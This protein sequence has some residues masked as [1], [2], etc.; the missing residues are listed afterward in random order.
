MRAPRST[1]SQ[2]KD[3]L[4]DPAFWFLDNEELTGKQENAIKERLAIE[5]KQAHACLSYLGAS[6]VCREERLYAPGGS[7][8]VGSRYVIADVLQGLSDDE[9][10]KL[11]IKANEKVHG[12]PWEVKDCDG[13]NPMEHAHG[14]SDFQRIFANCGKG[15]LWLFTAED[16]P[17]SNGWQNFSAFCEHVL[18]HNKSR[19]D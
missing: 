2:L 11:S 9:K 18:P 15:S 3:R 13:M 12:L 17:S 10:K 14:Q 8:Y 6:A 16:S 5:R 7:R 1:V 19:Y 4:R